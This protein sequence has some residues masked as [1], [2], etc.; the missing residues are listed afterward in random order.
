MQD[1]FLGL[2]F[3]FH[4][5][6]MITSSSLNISQR[7][8]LSRP[9]KHK[10]CLEQ[11]RTNPCHLQ[12]ITLTTNNNGILRIEIKQWI[13]SI[14]QYLKGLRATS[15][16]ACSRH[17]LPMISLRLWCFFG[18][19]LA[20]L[21]D[22]LGW[23]FSP[24]SGFSLKH[25]TSHGAVSNPHHPQIFRATLQSNPSTNQP[26]LNAPTI[27]S[28]THALVCTPYLPPVSLPCHLQL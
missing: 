21:G 4:G 25:Q 24:Y 18:N 6:W 1:I 28:S 12:R 23:L 16:H 5:S 20:V 15:S 14:P 7:K 27:S 8:S 22:A 19:L 26:T 3:R 13:F 2:L 10:K 11:R 9:Q 17:L